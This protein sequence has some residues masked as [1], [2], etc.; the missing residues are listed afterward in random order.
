MT[1]S[2][3]ENNLIQEDLYIDSKSRD[4][5]N[6]R[7]RTYDTSLDPNETISKSGSFEKDNVS[8]E[9]SKLNLDAEFN[10]ETRLFSLAKKCYSSII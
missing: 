7:Q 4:E 5:L 9:L 8:A 3:H 2:S 1:K 10:F 6:R